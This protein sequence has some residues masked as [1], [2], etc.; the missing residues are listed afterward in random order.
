MQL[1]YQ[2]NNFIEGTSNQL[3]RYAAYMFSKKSKN[4]FNILFLCGNAG[5]GKTHLLHAIGNK[6]LTENHNHKIIYIHAKNFIRNMIFSLKNNSIIHFKN[7]YSSIET[8][9]IDDIQYFF[10]KKKK[11]IFNILNKFLQKNQKIVLTTNFSINQ[12][13]K[14]SQNLP[15]QFKSGLITSINPPELI[16]KIHILLNKAHNNNIKLSYKMAKY[17]SQKMCA[18]IK[19][20]IFFLKKIHLKLI[21]KKKKM[22]KIFIKK[23]INQ[24]KKN[25][26]KSMNIYLIQKKVAAYF[27]IKKS[28]IISSKRRK[29]IVEPRQIAM[30]LIKKLTDYNYS[31]IGK[32]FGKKNHTTVLH[33][34]KKINY[35]KKKKNKIYYDFLYLFNQLNI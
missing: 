30:L 29:S 13:K 8:L 24:L 28:D 15:S 20:L 34:C 35:L 3:A 33:A 23:Q 1:N 2:F 7:F 14:I 5:C 22:T 25:K 27:N 4:F 17:I 11:K 21:L 26:K 12:I 10:Y 31:E 19:E 9:L 32:A 16:T 18:N 6:I